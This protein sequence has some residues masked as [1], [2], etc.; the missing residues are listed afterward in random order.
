MANRWWL[1]DPRERYWVETLS[2]RR[3]AL[4]TQL[5]APKTDASGRPSWRYAF[6]ADTRPGDVVLHWLKA[7]GG[8]I[9]WSIVDAVAESLPIEW[10]ARGSYGRKR[11]ADH[12]P[13]EGWRVPLRDY[14]SLA[15]PIGLPELAAHRGD[16][17]RVHADLAAEHGSPLYL[18]LSIY[19]PP[20]GV[21]VG[22]GYI[23]KW[24]AALNDVF[25][26]L[27][28]MGQ[29]TLGEP[30]NVA[31][32]GAATE[33]VTRRR[34]RREQRFL[35]AVELHAMAVA[36]AWY[37][38]QGYTVEDVSATKSWD[39]EAARDGELR[40]VEVKGSTGARDAVDLTANEVRNATSWIPTDLF[41]VD[42]IMVDEAPGLIRTS[43]G[44]S[45]RWAE[46][47]PAAAALEPVTYSYL[48]ASGPDRVD[49]VMTREHV[50]G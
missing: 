8:F 4:G 2:D 36:M 46:W 33:P 15:D 18:A 41:V 27:R 7:E 20:R 28:G 42:R 11:A 26:G 29:L 45:R 35:K 39:L 30:G 10:H 40:R 44:R 48:L 24:P 49:V 5:H 23:F 25:P 21:E 37:E 34:G 16:V 19:T 9:G 6:L 47:S 32:P 1:D 38:G 3:P 22:Q 50:G 43:G 14:Q 17:E 31:D 13:K 12:A